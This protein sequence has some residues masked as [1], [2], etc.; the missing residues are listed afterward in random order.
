MADGIKLY[1]HI[2]VSNSRGMNGKAYG[3]WR[4]ECF[5]SGKGITNSKVNGLRIQVMFQ[6]DKSG[7]QGCCI[8]EDG[9]EGGE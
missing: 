1:H 4:I 3:Q 9:L 8:V 7:V 2:R 6:N 5:S